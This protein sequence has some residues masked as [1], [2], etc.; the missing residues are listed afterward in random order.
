MKKIVKG[1]KIFLRKI[2]LADANKTY[3]GWLNDK[4]VNKFLETRH[5]KHTINLIKEFIKNCKLNN[6]L[7]LAICLNKNKKHIGNIKIGNINNYHKTADISYFIG[8]RD[9]WG[10]GYATEAVKLSVNIS[11]NELNLYKCFAGV[12]KKNV[13]SSKVLM[14]SGFKKEALIKDVFIYEN[15]RED[16]IIYSIKRKKNV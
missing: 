15:N 2:K 9:S 14:K 3:L 16:H 12:Y 8:D 13:A 11:F 6:S 4:S 7:L 10:F 1:K 5:Q